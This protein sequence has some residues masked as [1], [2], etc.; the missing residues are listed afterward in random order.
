MCFAGSWLE[1]LGNALVRKAEYPACVTDRQMCNS[2]QISG[3]LNAGRC[4]LSLQSV[5]L[6]SD[7]PRLADLLLEIPRKNRLDP[8]FKGVWR[9]IQK[10]GD[11]VSSHCLGSLQATSLGVHTPQLRNA[12]RPP[13]ADAL[14]TGRVGL[15]LHSRHQR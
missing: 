3:R 5:G 8:D 1:Q 2:N 15:S 14:T 10:D 4:R 12:D 13:V 6:L 11:R 7:L 9:D